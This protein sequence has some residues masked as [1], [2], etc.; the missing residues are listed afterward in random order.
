MPPALGPHFLREV[1]LTLEAVR[2]AH[3]SLFPRVPHAVLGSDGPA[4]TTEI[5]V[6]M[7]VVLV[8]RWE[9]AEQRGGAQRSGIQERDPRCKEKIF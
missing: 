6:A 3:S 2:S 5:P 9:N 7:E 1:T 8:D 4:V